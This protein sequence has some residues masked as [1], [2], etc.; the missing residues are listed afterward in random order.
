M[1]ARQSG[2]SSRTRRCPF[3]FIISSHK[4]YR[5][6]L[7]VLGRKEDVGMSARAAIAGVDARI[8]M[9]VGD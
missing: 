2:N 3:Q 6:R 5:L 9:P 7:R 4:K 1:E 8:D